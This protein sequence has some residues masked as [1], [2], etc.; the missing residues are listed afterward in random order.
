MRLEI[1]LI[2]MLS[3]SIVSVGFG[4]VPEVKASGGLALDGSSFTGGYDCVNVETCSL[5]GVSTRQSGDVII[6]FIVSSA[7]CGGHTLT[8][9]QHLTWVERSELS[10]GNGFY[11]QEFYS[12]SASTLTNDTLTES[13]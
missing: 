1:V 5:S 11:E 8:D 9:L 12:I 3:I 4:A 10:V 2:S 6:A 7:C 13:D